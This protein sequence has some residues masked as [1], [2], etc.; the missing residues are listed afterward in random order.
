MPRCKECKE[1]FKAK[2]F[3]QK[4]CMIKDQCIKAFSDSIQEK[5]WKKRKKVLKKNTKK[6]KEYRKELQDLVNA[7]IREIDKGFGCISCDNGKVEQAGH[8][9]SV[10]SNPHLRYD[11]FNIFG[12]CIHDNMHKGGKPIEFREGLIDRYGKETTEAFLEPSR[13]L[14]K[15][16]INDIEQLKKVVKAFLKYLKQEDKLYSVEETIQLRQDLL[17]DMQITLNG[18]A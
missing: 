8:Y 18:E 12:Q 4:Y 1:K 10:G 7:C 15:L 17:I 5:E 2:Y 3:N 9:R 6:P 13:P 11:P 14:N 16:T